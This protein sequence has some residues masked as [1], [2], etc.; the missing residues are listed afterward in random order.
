M[1]VAREMGSALRESA[2]SLNIRERLDYSC[3]LF[4]PS[5][6]LVAHAPHIPVHLGSMGSAVRA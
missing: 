3:A 4:D 6:R 1:A 2:Q 5:G